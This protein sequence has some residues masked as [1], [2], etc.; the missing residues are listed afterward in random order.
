MTSAQRII[1]NTTAQYTRTIINVGLSLYSTRLIL[2]ALGQSDFGIYSVVAGV[3]AMLA[4]VTNAL[5]TTTQRFLSFNYGKGDM[6]YVSRIFSNSLLLHLLIGAGVLV[7]L[8]ALGYPIVHSVLNIEDGRESAALYVYLAAVL[9]LTLTFI[10]APYRALFIAR[11]NIVYISIIDV[12]D[13][14]LRLLIAVFLT[15]ISSFDRLVTYSMLLVGI[16]V[17]NLLAFALYA[18]K[19]F[20]ECRHPHWSDWDRGILKELSG[21]AGWTVYS[22]GCVIVRNQGIAVLI[23]IFCSTI[24]NAAYGIAQQVS[25]AV[26]FISASIINAINPQIMSAEGQGNRKHMIQLAEYESK[27][28]FLL[29]SVISLPLIFE[30]DTILRLWL[31]EVPQYTVPFCQLMLLAAVF[32][33]LTIGLT[34]ANQAIGKIKIYTLWFYSFKLITVIGIWICLLSD[35]PVATSLWCYVAV[36]L[37]GSVMRLILMKHQ[38]HIAVYPFVRNVCFRVT[39]PFLSMSLTSYLC[40]RYLD[41]SYRFIFTLMMTLVVGCITIRF[42]A[43]DPSEKQYIH[44]FIRRNRK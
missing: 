39:V 11:E 3:V 1:V 35:V 37:L 14:T 29:L 42:T 27:Y 13:G 41:I 20:P 43:L 22:S 36:E 24:A 17:F 21:F 28:A 2:A 38:A 5:V 40:S 34:S 18:M 12:L 10:T 30:M 4:F 33:Q 19:N 15:Y 26:A 8:G 9:M 6:Q 32:D 44:E 16:S 31:G 25:G 23:N 7:V